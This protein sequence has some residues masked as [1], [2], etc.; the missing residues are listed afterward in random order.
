MPKILIVI[1]IV[2][3]VL[4]V[5]TTIYTKTTTPSQEPAVP[6]ANTPKQNCEELEAQIKDSVEQA[7]RCNEGSDC[8][9]VEPEFLVCP[10]GCYLVV[11]KGADFTSIEK[12]MSEY[13][14]KCPTCDYGCIM[15]PPLYKPLCTNNKCAFFVPSTGTAT[16]TDKTDEIICNWCG[17][18]CVKY[19]ISQEDC[20]KAKGLFGTQCGCPKAMH[21]ENFTCSET[22]GKCVQ[23]I[24]QAT[25]TQVTITTDKTEYAQE[26]TVRVTMKNN[27]DQSVGHWDRIG[28]YPF[29]IEEFKNNEW[30]RID[31]PSGCSCA[32]L[33]QEDAPGI[34]PLSAAK[35][36]NYE[37]RQT[38]DCEA[39]FVDKGRYRIKFTYYN[40]FDPTDFFKNAFT[41]YSNE[42]TITEA[43][44]TTL[45]DKEKI[46][47][48]EISPELEV[49]SKDYFEITIESGK[50]EYKCKNTQENSV[51]IICSYWTS[52][53]GSTP[54]PTCGSG[55][56]TIR[57][58][59]DI[60]FIDN[61]NTTLGGHQISGPYS[62][63][64][65]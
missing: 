5:G 26:K 27:L 12:D 57:I 61:F 21:P 30:W 15:P 23:S 10:F 24:K 11:N 35:E 6:A 18:T 9:I 56:K 14:K 50:E 34:I 37:W 13:S 62:L 19:P 47:A 42:F 44:T 16:T 17:T 64:N 41:I 38:K 58:C 55:G 46:C 22:N 4:I 8:T 20:E 48:T 60:Y 51:D 7:S 45:P 53:G 33:C 65:L 36:N 63:E 52:C 54:T 29:I 59:N 28:A 39:K 25:I 2:A 1:V 49:I 31:T 43:Y 3:A 40:P 32:P